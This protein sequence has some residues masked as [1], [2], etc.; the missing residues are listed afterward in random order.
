[1]GEI[2]RRLVHASGVV[3]PGVYLA[4]LLTW[5][6]FQLGLLGG[7]VLAVILEVLRLRFGLQEWWFYDRLTRDYEREKL[8]GYALYMFS[9]TAVALVFEPGIAIPAMLMVMLGDPVSGYLGS[10]E[11]RTV[12]GRVPL[13]AMFVV[14]VA[15]AFPFTL[16][17]VPSMTGG[18]LAAVVG[19]ALATAA[20]GIK[21]TIRGYVIDDNLTIP[22]AGAIGIWLVVTLVPV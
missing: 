8:A 19:A 1:M 18:L 5:E 3:I 13:G 10:G 22:P 14:C 20:D 4:G 11:L 15:V 9:I 2:G 21:P 6:Q 7:C 17:L 16:G 12:K